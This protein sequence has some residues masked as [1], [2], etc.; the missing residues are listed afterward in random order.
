VVRVLHNAHL[1]VNT[2]V[3]GSTVHGVQF[4]DPA[5]LMEPAA[6]YHRAGAFG[7]LFDA[8]APLIGDRPVAVVGLGAGG[9]ACHG[10]RGSAW[11]FFEIDPLVERVARDDRLFT[12]LRDCPPAST[13]VI[14]DARVTL[15]EA[16]DHAYAMIVMDAFTSDA[17][18]T[19]LLTREAIAAYRKKLAPDGLLVLHISNRHLDLAPV[20]G[21]LARDAGLVGRMSKAIAA[22]DSNTLIAGPAKVVVLAPT[23]TLLGPLAEHQDWMPLPT[24]DA[25]VWSDDHVDI[26]RALFRKQ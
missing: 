17:I 4:T 1:G 20:V 26:V 25:P 13:V 14:G 2:F 7:Q 16:P 15:R 10:R 8:A 24:D 5:R 18:P 9:L 12:F 23:S 22:E 19:H 21:N 3:H 6:Y 11:T